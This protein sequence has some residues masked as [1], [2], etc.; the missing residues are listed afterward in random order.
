[1]PPAQAVTLNAGP[2]ASFMAMAGSTGSGSQA[3]APMRPRDFSA[4]ARG[5]IARAARAAHGPLAPVSSRAGRGAV[6]PE[7][8]WHTL[9]TAIPGAFTNVQLGQAQ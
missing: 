2:S 6:W 5:C 1:M 4:L 8:L 9:Q 7:G 3:P